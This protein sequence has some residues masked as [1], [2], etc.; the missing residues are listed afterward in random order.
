M[1]NLRGIQVVA[2]QTVVQAQAQAKAN[3]A[4]AGGESQAIKIITSQLR[5]DPQYLQWQ[6][7]NKWNGQLPYSLGGQG[8]VPFF[9]LPQSP[10]S[11]SQQQQQQQNQSK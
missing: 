6:A 8:A 10:S 7:I 1:N 4:K 5:Q 2:N 11:S 9:Q 3:I